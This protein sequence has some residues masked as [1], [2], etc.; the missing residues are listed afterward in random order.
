MALK[1]LAEAQDVRVPPVAA[2]ELAGDFI[3][4]R[5]LDALARALAG[6]WPELEFLERWRVKC[7]WKRKGS[8]SRGKAKLATIQVASGLVKHFAD[9]DYIVLVSADQARAYNLTPFQ[10]EALMYHE[11]LHADV[12]GGGDDEDDEKPSSK[13]HDFEAF[14]LEVQR[15]GA[16]K[17]DLTVAAASF[18][19]MALP[20][21]EQSSDQLSPLGRDAT[22][23]NEETGEIIGAGA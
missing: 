23:V 22:R 15:Y 19:Q 1:T 17:A 11:L 14:N 12:K 6:K 13:G 21:F 8:V 3:Q 10:F 20:G 4:S 5:E 9:T 2:F 7:L 16:W 18:E